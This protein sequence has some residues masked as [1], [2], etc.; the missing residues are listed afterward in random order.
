MMIRIRPSTVVGNRLSAIFFEK[1]SIFPDN[2][3][4]RDVIPVLIVYITISISTIIDN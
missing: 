1:I 3:I 2:T 4:Y